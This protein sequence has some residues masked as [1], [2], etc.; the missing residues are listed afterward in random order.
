MKMEIREIVAKNYTENNQF[1]EIKIDSNPLNMQKDKKNTIEDKDV[2]YLMMNKEKNNNNTSDEMVIKPQENNPYLRIEEAMVNKPIVNYC[3][4]NRNDTIMSEKKDFYDK[5]P[6]INKDKRNEI[7]NCND[8][9]NNKQ[10]QGKFNFAT[11]F[12]N[13]STTYDKN[14]D[15]KNATFDEKLKTKNEIVKPKKLMA[16]LNMKKN[17]RKM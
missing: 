17:A 9:G 16:P 15:L 13:T 4:N 12:I 10:D 7:N 8:K 1:E 11:H 5:I 6:I 14:A 3:T 2:L